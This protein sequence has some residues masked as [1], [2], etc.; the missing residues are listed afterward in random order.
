MI[1]IMVYACPAKSQWGRKDSAV[2]SPM[3]T[4]RLE[5]TLPLAAL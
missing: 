1:Q 2:S 3:A 4:H 5:Y